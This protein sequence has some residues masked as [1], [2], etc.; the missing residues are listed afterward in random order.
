MGSL[1]GAWA[2]FGIGA[3]VFG[4]AWWGQCL[5]IFGMLNGVSAWSF[6]NV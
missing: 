5:E 2:V 6:G 4:D 3:C 1:P